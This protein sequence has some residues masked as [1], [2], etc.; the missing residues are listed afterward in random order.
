M[1]WCPF[2]LCFLHKLRVFLTNELVGLTIWVVLLEWLGNAHKF[3]CQH[4]CGKLVHSARLSHHC[5]LFFFL[6]LLLLVYHF[7]TCYRWNIICIN[8]FHFVVT[9]SY[10]VVWLFRVYNCGWSRDDL[11]TWFYIFSIMW[12]LCLYLGGNLWL[13]S[14]LGQ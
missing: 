13:C 6:L 12:T 11:M 14:I 10:L 1:T 3:H 9:Y 2:A 4:D 5:L 7:S 8:I